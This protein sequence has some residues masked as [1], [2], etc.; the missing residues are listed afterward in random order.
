MIPIFNPALR[1]RMVSV[2]GFP[3]DWQK[4]QESTR[5]MADAWNAKPGL[6]LG[7]IYEEL[8]A[9][10][11]KYG[12]GVERDYRELRLALEHEPQIDLS[13]LIERN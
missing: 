6:T 8:N 12:T 2:K 10:G 1:I 7:D 13:L 9:L 5:A 4:L 11:I 3:H